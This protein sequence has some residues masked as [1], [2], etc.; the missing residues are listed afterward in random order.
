MDNAPLHALQN[1]TDGPNGVYRYGSGGGFPT[2]SWQSSNYWV[3]VT[4][5]S[6]S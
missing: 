4:F 5:T 3:D 6:A 2:S 1:G